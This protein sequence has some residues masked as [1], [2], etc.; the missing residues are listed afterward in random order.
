MATSAQP[1]L[2]C[3]KSTL[4][5]AMCLQSFAC[6]DVE[7]HNRPEVEVGKS[8]EVLLNPVVIS[9]NESERVLIEGSINSVRVSI[10]VKQADELEEV[11]VAKFMRFLMQRAEQFVVLRRKPVEG[12]NISFLIT[13]F[14]TE[15]MYKHK[16]VDFVIQFMEDIDKEVSAMKL[17]VNSR[18][19][20]V[21]GKFLECFC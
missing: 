4:T 11:L 9:R 10:K 17:G 2:A 14:H 20:V 18:G 16:V 6:Q 8:T 7:R 5:A 15:T 19:R 21:A 1:Y 3:V 13:N 12:Y